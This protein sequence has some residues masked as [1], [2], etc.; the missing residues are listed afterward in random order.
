MW[1]GQ[2]EM[3]DT[4]D[5]SEVISRAEALEFKPRQDLEKKFLTARLQDE[6]SSAELITHRDEVGQP[7][8]STQR[9]IF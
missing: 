9:K 2:E 6:A 3:T 5:V 4:I 1:L 8:N 7:S